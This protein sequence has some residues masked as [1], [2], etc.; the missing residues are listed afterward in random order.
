M[1]FPVS[2]LHCLSAWATS[3]QPW[4]FTVGLRLTIKTVKTPSGPC[5][6]KHVRRQQGVDRLHQKTVQACPTFVGLR[7]T[8]CVNFLST[9]E[10]RV[11]PTLVC[12]FALQGDAPH[13]KSR[14]LTK[15]SGT[16]EPRTCKS[17]RQPLE[18]PRLKDSPLRYPDSVLP[19]PLLL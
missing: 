14:H 11:T 15:G 12:F 4:P 19:Q 6:I 3:R 7:V 2:A 9:W 1:V 10:K 8:V 5:G 17:T 13:L 16:L 18:V